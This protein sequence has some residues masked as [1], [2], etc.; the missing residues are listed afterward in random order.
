MRL[1][2]FVPV[3]IFVV[4]DSVEGQGFNAMTSLEFWLSFVSTLSGV[5]FWNCRC[6]YKKTLDL[7]D[8]F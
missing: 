3:A 7:Y 1:V 4:Y 6:F 8:Y 5:I 2:L